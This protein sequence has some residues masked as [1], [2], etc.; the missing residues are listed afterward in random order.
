MKDIFELLKANNYP[1]R[2]I[3]IGKSSDGQNA[4]VAYFI[5]GR[6]INS[7][8]RIFIKTEDGIQIRPYKPEDLEDPSLII[9]NPIKKV[10]SNYVVTNGDQTH[11]IVQF[12]NQNKTFEE[13]LRTRTFEP[14]SPN[15]TPRISGNLEFVENDFS[16][17]M[18]I[19]KSADSKGTACNRFTFSYSSLIGVGHFIHTYETNS[20]PLESFVGEPREISIDLD[21]EEFTNK[22]WDSLDSENKISLFV[23]YI[24]LNEFSVLDEIKNKNLG[25]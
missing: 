16:Y 19:L 14:D 15:F 23:S 12:L 11:T 10:G 8:N 7:R 25:D 20:S 13:A 9:Y 18:S 24:N 6:S 22:L 3:I 17:K 1:G 4:V 5:M 2:G 21:I